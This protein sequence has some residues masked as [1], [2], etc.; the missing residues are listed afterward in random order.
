MM[1]DF[2]QAM[3]PIL[4]H[5]SIVTHGMLIPLVPLLWRRHVLGDAMPRLVAG[6]AIHLEV[7][8]TSP[9]TRF[10]SIWLPWPVK[11]PLGPL[12]PFWLFAKHSA[13][14]ATRR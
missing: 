14:R 3:L 4:H 13:T 10:G 11:L 12:S 7:D 2:G 8:L 9:A 1:P 5:R 6:I